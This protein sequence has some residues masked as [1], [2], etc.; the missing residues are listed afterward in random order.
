VVSLHAGF[1]PPARRGGRA[2]GDRGDRARW[3]RSPHRGPSRSALRRRGV[4]PGRPRGGGTS[5]RGRA[6]DRRARP[7]SCPEGPARRAV[8]PR[9]RCADLAGFGPPCP[10]TRTVTSR[11]GKN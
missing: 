5:P 4:T 9:L 8:P 1:G 10:P 3:E 7:V 2:D 11:A 6:R